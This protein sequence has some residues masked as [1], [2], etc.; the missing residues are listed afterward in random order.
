MGRTIMMLID[1]E[2]VRVFGDSSG[3]DSPVLAQR[4]EEELAARESVVA[5]RE[6]ELEAIKERLQVW[7]ERLRRWD[8]ELVGR[9][10]RVEMASKLVSGP[11]GGSTKVGRN[12]RCPCRSGLKYKQCHGLSG[13]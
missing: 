8:E 6:C 9:Q 11:L 5:V 3:D 1:R 7:T 4:A 13:R 12:E 2:L 10:Q